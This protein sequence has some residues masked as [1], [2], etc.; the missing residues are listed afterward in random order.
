MK[1]KACGGR[2]IH[3]WDDGSRSEYG[4][5]IKQPS[6]C[7]KLCDK[8]DEC[9]GFVQRTSDNT[10]TMWRR[11]PFKPYFTTKYVCH[12]KLTGMS[13]NSMD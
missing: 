4:S 10:C 9:D 5:S 11:A 8:H 13:D 1:N 12:R 6:E 2:A 3:S 7:R